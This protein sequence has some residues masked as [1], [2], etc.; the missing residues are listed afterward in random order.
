[1]QETRPFNL[2]QAKNSAP[3]VTRAGNNV[4]IVCFDKKAPSG[5]SILAL[6][7][8]P[9]GYEKLCIYNI[10]GRANTVEETPFDLLMAPLGHVEGKPVFYGNTY[11]F[12]SPAGQWLKTEA[13]DV[14][15]RDST[16]RRWPKKKVIKEVW[17]AQWRDVHA[18]LPYIHGPIH[19]TERECIDSYGRMPSFIKAV[20]T[21][22]YEVEE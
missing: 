13:Y 2:D 1:M 5:Y 10:H 21:G 11:E 7:A 14:L 8:Q 16:P 15:P 17:Q 3:I 20:K 6:V 12:Q 22:E 4:R 9:D 18:G 19:F